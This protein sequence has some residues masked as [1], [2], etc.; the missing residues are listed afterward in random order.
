MVAPDMYSLQLTIQF[1]HTI[2]FKIYL[3]LHVRFLTSFFGRLPKQASCTC[4]LD[5]ACINSAHSFQALFCFIISL[6]IF[7]LVS[8]NIK[9]ACLYYV[10]K[11]ALTPTRPIM[12]CCGIWHQNISSTSFKSCT[13]SCKSEPSWTRLDCPAHSTH[14]WLEWDRINLEALLYFL[15]L[16]KTI[17]AEWWGAL[18]AE[19][20][21]CH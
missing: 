4:T 6:C 20:S 10:A 21:H 3:T 18:P 8:H 13:V 19:K 11:T 5:V 2:L 7:T 15:N 16:F 12:V 9:T 17:F 14:A 1:I